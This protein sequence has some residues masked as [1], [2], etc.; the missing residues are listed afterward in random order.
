MEY[1][2]VSDCMVLVSGYLTGAAIVME[3]TPVSSTLGQSILYW[4]SVFEPV[5]GPEVSR[6]KVDWQRMAPPRLGGRHPSPLL[7]GPASS[8][9]IFPTG[10][11]PLEA[12]RST[13]SGPWCLLILLKTWVS[14]FQ[15]KHLRVGPTSCSVHNPPVDVPWHAASHPVL[16]ASAWNLTACFGGRSD[17]STGEPTLST[18]LALPSVWGPVGLDCPYFVKTG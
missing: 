12:I 13:W 10:L 5:S 9:K 7:M 8:C 17:C 4:P 2:H 11:K 16:E 3:T 18:L 15:S 1:R 14:N 6:S